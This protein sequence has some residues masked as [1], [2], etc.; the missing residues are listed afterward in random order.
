[1]KR[2]FIKCM[3]LTAMAAVL[4]SCFP[5]MEYLYN[6][7]SM[8][9]VL[10]RDRLQT[11][12]GDIFNITQNNSGS[13]IPDTLKR[14]MVRCDVLSAVEGRTDEYNVRLEEFAGALCQSPVRK[15]TMNA[16]TIGSNGIN[17]SQAW[18]SGGYINA[19][20][21]LT[22]LNPPQADHNI[23]LV[24][25]DVRSNS[26]TLYFEMR[27]NA[28]EECPENSSIPLTSFIFAGTYMSFP[29]DGIL[30]SGQKPVCHIEWDWYDGDE[31]TLSSNKIHRSG[32][33]SVQ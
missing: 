12:N 25:D 31:Y 1:M 20:V 15:S 13:T 22:M 16:A 32:D 21:L 27:H 26:D 29:L 33:I 24:Y 5:D 18:V 6:E 9:T 8:C 23:N 10:S 4:V 3:V 28:H 30:A 2:T 17:I 19:Y 11:D 14:V 7:T